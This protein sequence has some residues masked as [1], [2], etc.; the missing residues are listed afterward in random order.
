MLFFA[1]VSAICIPHAMTI[2][3]NRN[4]CSSPS[5]LT[6]VLSL[7]GISAVASGPSENVRTI[8][9]G[10]VTYTRWPQLSG[11]P[12]LCIFQHHDISIAW[13]K[14]LRKYCLINPWLF[15]IHKKPYRRPAMVFILAVNRRPNSLNLRP[16]ME[17]GPYYLLRNK[18]PIALLAALFACSSTMR[19]SDF[20]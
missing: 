3:R 7:V 19:E 14:T 2:W 16:N 6:L 9:S 4:D 1:R 15:V 5:L 20:P 8:V 12:R 18:T 11:P 13:P 17:T 10:I